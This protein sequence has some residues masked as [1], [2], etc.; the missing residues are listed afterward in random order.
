[1][2]VEVDAEGRRRSAGDAPYLDYRPLEATDPSTTELLARPE[3]AFVR[4][5]VT[6]QVMNY[7]VTTVAREHADTVRAR[8]QSRVERTSLAVRDRLTKE[9]ARWDHRA[10]TLLEQELAGKVNARL[11]AREAQRRANELSAR[12]SARLAELEREAD[13]A[14][15]AP[16]VVGAAL[17]IPRGLLDL[18]QGVGPT[19]DA[20]TTVDRLAIAARAREIV[21]IRERARGFV[22]VD[23][24]FEHVGYDIESLNPAS[25]EVRFIEVKG[26]ADGAGQITVTR[27]ELVTALNRPEQFILAVIEFADDHSYRETYLRAPF[28]DNP[29]FS[30]ISRT[31]DLSKLISVGIPDDV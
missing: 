11:N 22:P 18:V 28:R 4:G 27:N 21:M 2:K 12:L 8:V 19:T 31:Y 14:S 20:A 6:E 5:D 17:V 23:R 3:C 25:G 1:M 24:E 13:I 10:A 7:A 15:L 26:R 30:E 16:R 29:S 9:I